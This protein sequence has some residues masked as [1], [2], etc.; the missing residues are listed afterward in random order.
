MPTRPRWPGP[1]KRER[2]ARERIR[3]AREPL[4]ADPSNDFYDPNSPRPR[5]AGGSREREEDGSAA[6]VFVLVGVSALS[7]A[8]LIWVLS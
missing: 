4:F 8:G 3:K 7:M 1:S 5:V 2:P 6:V